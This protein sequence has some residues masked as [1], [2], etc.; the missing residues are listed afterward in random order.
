MRSKKKDEEDPS[1]KESIDEMNSTLKTILNV[2]N[3][4]QQ[5]MVDVFEEFSNELKKPR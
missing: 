3:L 5:I 4:Q 2:L 1:I